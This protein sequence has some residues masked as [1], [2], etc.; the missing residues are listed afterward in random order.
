MISIS[1]IFGHLPNQVYGKKLFEHIS[2]GTLG[3][4]ILRSKVIPLTLFDLLGL[5]CVKQIL[6]L[7]QTDQGLCNR[8]DINMGGRI[9][10]KID[11]EVFT[12]VQVN[13]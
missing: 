1:Q 9:I 6:T 13:K 12:Y 4:S 7:I 8:D 3:V 5:W 10:W 2:T 11:N